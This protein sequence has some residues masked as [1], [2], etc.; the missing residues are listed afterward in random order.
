MYNTKA[1]QSLLYNYTGVYLAMNTTKGYRISAVSKLT[2]IPPET[3]RIWEYR[4]SIIQPTRSPSGTRIYNES[5]IHHLSLLKQ[6]VDNGD[7]IGN[8]AALSTRKLEE[9]LEDYS[10][11]QNKRFFNSS[12]KKPV[13]RVCVLGSILPNRFAKLKNQQGPIQFTGL[14]TTKS[15]FESGVKDAKPDLLILEY[16]TI[17][18]EDIKLV[19]AIYRQSN[20]S[21][22]LVIYQFSNTEALK[23]LKHEDIILHHGY[24]DYSQVL[25]ICN[26]PIPDQAGTKVKEPKLFT[27]RT[28]SDQD[29]SK[30]SMIES[31]IPCECPRHLAE[32]LIKLVAFENYSKQCE[33]RNEKD[34][35]IHKSL[36]EITSY[37]RSQFE[38][39]L[40]TVLKHENID[41]NI[42]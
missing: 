28:Y 9:R 32:I 37:A 38:S 18:K 35:A 3:L 33:D 16:P 41:I 30:V 10:N 4:Y 36:Y 25:N 29:L 22:L 39:A 5:D 26:I 24:L 19:K 34:E 15:E 20:A 27:Q 8:L 6:L 14:Y 23:K 31:S 40:D 17:Q 12:S 21:R 13:S 42:I 1:N 2:G 7:S 11:I